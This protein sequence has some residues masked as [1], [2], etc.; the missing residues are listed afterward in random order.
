MEKWRS[1]SIGKNHESLGSNTG[2]ITQ[3]FSIEQE[4]RNTMR[5]IRYPNGVEKSDPIEIKKEAVA[6]FTKWSSRDIGCLSLIL[7]TLSPIDA[8][9]PWLKP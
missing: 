1:S 7:K 3:P 8:Q 2:I 6:Y 9:F 4:K 5:K